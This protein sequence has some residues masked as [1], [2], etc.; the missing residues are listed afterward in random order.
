MPRNYLPAFPDIRGQ[1]YERM[2][3]AE[4]QQSPPATANDIVG[5]TGSNISSGVDGAI[6]TPT[7][8]RYKYRLGWTNVTTEQAVDIE[9]ASLE[10][11]V[12]GAG[13]PIPF[14]EW[15]TSGIFDGEYPQTAFALWP[16]KW[17]GSNPFTG[18]FHWWDFNPAAV[19]VIR[20]TGSGYGG[21]PVLPTI[22]V[23]DTW[24]GNIPTFSIPAAS[25]TGKGITAGQPVFVSA[26]GRRIRMVTVEAGSY[27]REK[28]RVPDQWIVNVTLV[29]KET[30]IAP[31][32]VL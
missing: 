24:E 25:L 30:G 31:G 11:S 2:V 5:V 21:S 13:A 23:D 28:A 27:S 14:I 8:R 29:E 7:V 19:V 15:E 9:H 18:P 20:S 10:L 1:T 6:I 17:S 22:T 3:I 32:Y 16:G 4:T 12:D 26:A